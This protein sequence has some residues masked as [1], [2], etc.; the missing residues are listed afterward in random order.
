MYQRQLGRST[1]NIHTYPHTTR[2]FECRRT[3]SQAHDVLSAPTTHASTALAHGHLRAPRV[4]P[5]PKTRK[6]SRVPFHLPRSWPSN[7]HDAERPSNTRARTARRRASS[8]AQLTRHATRR[9]RTS[10]SLC[11]RSSPHTG[12]NKRQRVTAPD[13]HRG[14]SHTGSLQ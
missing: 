13:G 9:C 5:L 4:A 11:Q 14:Y 7:A 8:I 3:A 12:R 10:R 1:R 6:A 2:T